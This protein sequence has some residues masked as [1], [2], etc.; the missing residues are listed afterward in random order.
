VASVLIAHHGERD[1][2]ERRMQHL[3]SH[4]PPRSFCQRWCA[5]L[6]GTWFA[7]FGGTDRSA[8]MGPEASSTTRAACA[9]LAGRAA[10]KS[11]TIVS[12]NEEGSRSEDS[13][14]LLRSSTPANAFVATREAADAG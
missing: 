8:A 3:Y 6:G 14:V 1:A 2:H 11:E 10:S 7:L 5:A 12:T 4:T 9:D 13:V